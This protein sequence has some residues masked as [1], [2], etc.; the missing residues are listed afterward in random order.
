VNPVPAPILFIWWGYASLCPASALVDLCSIFC[1]DLAVCGLET[2]EITVEANPSD[3]TAEYCRT[4]LTGGIN[5][6]SIGIQSFYDPILQE[7]A[8]GILHRKP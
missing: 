3:L 5:R 4:L 8:A 7:C 6:L 1:S 2:D